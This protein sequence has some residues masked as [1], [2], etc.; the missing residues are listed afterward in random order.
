MTETT[1]NTV[2]FQLGETEVIRITDATAPFPYPSDK[3]FPT[4]TAGEWEAI[5]QRYPGSF[6]N[7]TTFWGQVSC[8]LIRRPGR[9]IL[10]DT[11]LGP[12]NP[13][14]PP[15]GVSGQL[16]AGLRREGVEPGQVDTVFLTHLHPDHIGWNM[17]HSEGTARPTFPQARYVA[18]QADWDMGEQLLA[19]RPDE[20]GH[21]REQ[22]LPLREGGVLSLIA[23]ETMVAE[24]IYAIPT[25]GHSP[26][27]MSLQLEANGGEKL[28]ILGDAFYHPLQITGPAHHFA[29]DGDAPTAN[30]TRAQLLDR[31]EAGD[32]VITACHFPEP[33][34]GRVRREGAQRYWQPI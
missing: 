16:L 15:G 34:F 30:V 22:I 17:Q 13:A 28:L 14:V 4:V 25:P 21:I 33:G 31:I 9:T 1:G 7:P 29:I 18:P 24:G 10:V 32:M 27:H 3:V 12:A 5:R 8:Y 23:G 6:I 20:A 2:K 19:A 11:G 26:G